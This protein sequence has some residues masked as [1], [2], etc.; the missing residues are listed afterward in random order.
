MPIVTVT[1][2]PAA[3]ET[4]DRVL[5][6]LVVD[7]AAAVGCTVDDVWASFISAA[8]Q[9]MGSRRANA[10]DQCPIVVI[11]GRARNDAAIAAGLAAAAQAVGV[12]LG[13]PV[14]DV[15]LQWTDVVAGRAHAGGNTL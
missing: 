3:A 9:H 6:R 7:V 8:G 4:V 13:V 15:W 11:R 5:A 14:E 2:I 12:E 10:A 1:A